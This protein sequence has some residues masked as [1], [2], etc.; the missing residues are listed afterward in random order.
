MADSKSSVGAQAILGQDHLVFRAVFYPVEV[1]CD[2]SAG[3]IMQLEGGVVEDAGDSEGRQSA[4]KSTED[5]RRR[6]AAA[7]DNATDEHIIA[8]ANVGAGGDVQWL[9]C[10]GWRPKVEFR[11]GE[12]AVVAFATCDKHLAVGQQRRRV[13]RRAV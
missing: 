7:D 13:S 5:N 2:F 9:G 8:G 11:A 10:R 4:S 6:I 3:G 1:D 12:R